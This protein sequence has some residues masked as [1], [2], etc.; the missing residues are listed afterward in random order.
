[1]GR[2]TQ[3]FV[4][5][6]A[7][8][9][10]GFCIFG[11]PTTAAAEMWQ[12]VPQQWVLNTNASLNPPAPPGDG[13]PADASPK[14]VED[15]GD[16]KKVAIDK[17]SSDDKIFWAA[18]RYLSDWCWEETNDFE[19]VIRVLGTN[20]APYLMKL[21]KGDRFI[22]LA[23]A[24]RSG[25]TAD[26]VVPS[27]WPI[28]EE[29]LRKAA[30]ELE[31]A[32]ELN[33][34]QHLIAECMMTVELGQGKGRDQ[35]ELWFKRAMQLDTNN[36]AA[37]CNKLLYLEP[38]WY[39]STRDEIAFGR[40]C[41]AST[42]WGGKVPLMLVQA[43]RSLT[44]YLPEDK[45]KRDAYWQIPSVWNDVQSAY[46]KYLKANPKDLSEHKNYAVMAYTGRHWDVLNEQLAILGPDNYALFGSE[47]TIFDIVGAA[48][49][50]A[51][52]PNQ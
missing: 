40:E 35:L 46:N 23:W 45:E 24:A 32:W 2:F 18:S 29:Y 4:T 21:I 14:Q 12:S 37:C 8:L 13:L 41:V 22:G 36:V 10:A 39:G 34:K 9:F 31:A 27:Q 43:H 17:N 49:Q 47:D 26:K 7:L 48:K 50:H 44:E 6:S 15:F 25:A 3:Q 16:F 11:P 33:P 19:P 30:V 20:R 52:K 38:K 42:N 1:M 28:F 5:I 51:A